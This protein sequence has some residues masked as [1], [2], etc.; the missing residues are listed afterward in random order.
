MVFA[1]LL[2]SGAGI[3]VY[4]LAGASPLLVDSVLSFGVAA[5]LV[6]EMMV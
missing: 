2:T 1:L 4:F 5:L 6:I 3:G